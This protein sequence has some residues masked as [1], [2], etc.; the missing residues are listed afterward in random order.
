[1]DLRSNYPYW[2]L[3]QGI[4]KSYPSLDRDV[5]TEVVVIGA[6][7]SGALVAWYLCKAGIKTV[8]VDRRHVGMGST[9][10][11]TALLQYE[12]DTPLVELIKLVGKKNAVRSYLLCLDT[13]GEL[14]KISRRIPGE[15]GFKRKPSFQ[16]ASFKKDIDAL[17]LEYRARKEA[18]ISIRLLDEKNI[19]NRFGFK[20]E[21]GL[22]SKDGAE[23]DA[24]AL[25][26][27]LLSDCKR[28][29]IKIFDHTEIIDIHHEKRAVELMTWEGWKIKARKV[30]IAC[31]YESEKYLPKKI[32]TLQTTYAI[33]SEPF[34]RQDL[35]YKN[36]LIWETAR[37]YIYLRTTRDNRILIG[38]MDDDF[39]SGQKRD[40]ALPG[41]IKTLEK[42]FASLFPQL[43]FKMDFAWAG[44]FG[45]TKDGLP[46][47]GAIAQ[48]PNTY[49]ALGFG[50]N[51]ITFSVLAANIIRDLIK[52]KST[53]DAAIF[54]FTR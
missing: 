17:E 16:F 33:I 19:E 8:V 39:S 37:P 44:A 32:Q 12:I 50:G 11:S 2:L 30:V 45:S 23:V 20:K 54:S 24:Y 18:G 7:I 36:A 34:L 14:E 31:G 10:A 3:N 48:R 25:T 46:Y 28:D 21:A 22:L 27:G 47:I 4:I 41:K 43:N 51:G 15:I 35:W 53:P 9:S 52:G 42:T 49:F 29:G 5:K 40:A 1:M 26:H 13:I 38:G 6:G